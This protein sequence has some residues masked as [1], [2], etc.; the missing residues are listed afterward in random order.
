VAAEQCRGSA[1]QGE[2]GGLENRPTLPGPDLRIGFETS[3]NWVLSWQ[4]R[5]GRR[6]SVCARA[7]CVHEGLRDLALG[8]LLGYIL[9]MQRLEVGVLATPTCQWV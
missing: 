9:Y 3:P 5:A 2:A 7:F 1:T 6:A 8:F 4:E